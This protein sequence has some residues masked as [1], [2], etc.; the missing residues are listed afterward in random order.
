MYGSKH[1]PNVALFP[2]CDARGVLTDALCS[3]SDAPATR[4]DALVFAWRLELPAA[5]SVAD[6]ANAILVVAMSVPRE[7][8]TREQLL[9]IREL[10]VLSG[11]EER[12]PISSKV[13]KGSKRKRAP[14]EALKSVPEN[15]PNPSTRYARDAE[16]LKPN[17]RSNGRKRAPKESKSWWSLVGKDEPT[18][19]DKQ[20][21]TR[22]ERVSRE[23]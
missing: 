17:S 16:R 8:W 11:R 22:K 6:A 5:M 21:K 18:D 10:M 9:I 14:Q 23:P 15:T 4:G 1:L 7:T 20:R 2:L 13:V 3:T 19:I 12:L